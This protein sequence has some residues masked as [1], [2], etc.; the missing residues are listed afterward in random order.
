MTPSEVVAHFG[1]VRRVTETLGITQQAFS[2]WQRRGYIPLGRQYELQI[3]TGGR[4]V[5]EREKEATNG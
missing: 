5:A 3:L 2:N 1:S 4:L